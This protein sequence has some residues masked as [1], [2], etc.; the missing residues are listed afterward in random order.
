MRLAADLVNDLAAEPASLQAGRALA[1][2]T[3]QECSAGVQVTQPTWTRA[4]GRRRV[5]SRMHSGDHSRPPR[6]SPASDRR[7]GVRV[8][9][10]S[11]ILGSGSCSCPPHFGHTSFDSGAHAGQTNDWHFGQ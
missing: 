9:Y 4:T 3:R 6:S 10:Q 5:R 8:R 7:G 11:P 1:V 2:P